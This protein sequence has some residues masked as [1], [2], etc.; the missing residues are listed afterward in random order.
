MSE[1]LPPPLQLHRGGI[2]MFYWPVSNLPADPPVGSVEISV[3]DELTWHAAT[4]VA[5]EA[6]CLVAHPSVVSP[7]A[8]AA[9]AVLGLMPMHLRFTDT[10]EVVVRNAGR[11]YTES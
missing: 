1:K 5:G 9:V 4:I 2:E 7:P 6:K 3:D 11:L 10:P 8:G